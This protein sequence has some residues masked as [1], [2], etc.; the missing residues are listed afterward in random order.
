MPPTLPHDAD[1]LRHENDAAFSANVR[2]IAPD[3][4]DIISQCFG[5]QCPCTPHSRNDAAVRANGRAI[6]PD[7]RPISSRRFGHQCPCAPHSR[8]AL[9][10]HGNDAAFSMKGQTD[11]LIFHTVDPR[12]RRFQPIYA[13]PA[14]KQLPIIAKRQRLTDPIFHAVDP[15]A[16]RFQPIYALPAEKQLPIIAKRQRSTDPIFHSTDSRRGISADMCFSR[17]EITGLTAQPPQAAS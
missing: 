7:V 12:A 17:T 10:A 14:E 13:L 15:R 5:H 3:F 6:A 1:G 11:N 4:H 16:R 8:F 9:W 2:A